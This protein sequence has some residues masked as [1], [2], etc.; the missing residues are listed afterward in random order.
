META[1]K[2]L[3]PKQFLCFPRLKDIHISDIRKLYLEH[4]NIAEINNMW[5]F[6]SLE[7]LD[8]SSN[9]IEKIQGL[10]CL[11][12]LTCLNL[13]FNSIRKIEGLWTLRKLEELDLS[14]NRISVIE[15]LDS[16]ENLTHFFVADNLIGDMDNVLQLKTFENLFSLNLFGNPVSKDDDFIIFI[17]AHMPNLKYL[18]YTLLD[19]TIRKEAVA[20]YQ[21]IIE[22]MKREELQR[23]QEEE[24][25][26]LQKAE[27]QLHKDAFVESLNGSHLFKNMFRG[28]PEAER[29]SL[30]PEVAGLLHTFEHQMVELCM[31]LFE[32]GLAEHKRRD[33][34]VNSFLSEQDNLIADYQQKASQMLDWFDEQ[35]KESRAGVQQ[36]SDPA[37][38]DVKIN[39]CND[40]IDQLCKGLMTL[41]FQLVSQ[42]EDNARKFDHIISEMVGNLSENA[43]GIFAQFRD[44]E[45]NYHQKV[46]EIAASILEKMT[47]GDLEENLSEDV[48]MLF[49]EKDTVMDALAAAHDNHL[50]EINDRETQLVTGLT[51]WKA[52]LIKGIQDNQTRQNRTRISDI[53]RYKEH[54]KEQLEELLLHDQ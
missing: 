19:S 13:S 33:A 50:M 46:K 40:E 10:D 44:L 16:L 51:G 28:D 38:L 3:Y 11:V 30:I 23:Q 26:R 54:L 18:N 9:R 53:Q 5:D 22:K 52:A 36:L 15:N 20:K 21:Y 27:M 7:S 37:L 34:E 4:K 39:K 17:T 35:H 29:L 45:D 2:Q 31:Q 1:F 14:C 49:S 24:A 6:T 12:N 41:E 48:I 47:K 32:M 43:L 42:L 8:L 25:Q